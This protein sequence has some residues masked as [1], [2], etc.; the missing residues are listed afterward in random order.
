MAGTPGLIKSGSQLIKGRYK[1]KVN[2]GTV[3]KLIGQGALTV[4]QVSPVGAQASAVIRKVN[5][6][7]GAV[8]VATAPFTSPGAL[9]GV[10]LDGDGV[11][12]TV[13]LRAEAVSIVAGAVP[14]II[15]AR[16]AK[17]SSVSQ[18]AL[19]LE[20]EEYTNS[21]YAWLQQEATAAA[22]RAQ[23]KGESTDGKQ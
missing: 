9:G 15:N 7:A 22:D 5:Q 13:D 14:Q 11:P 2:W 17:S 23:A 6:V 8:G 21:V 20:L 16:I 4:A 19:S 1:M 18:F 12:D 10:D 3:I